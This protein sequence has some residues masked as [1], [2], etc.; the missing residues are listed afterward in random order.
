MFFNKGVFYLTDIYG[1]AGLKSGVLY[2]I[3][4]EIAVTENSR[5]MKTKFQWVLLHSVT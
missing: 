3:G 2:F 1:F 5:F 4:C